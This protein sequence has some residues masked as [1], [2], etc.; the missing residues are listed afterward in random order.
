MSERN[1]DLEAT[2]AP[3][4]SEAYRL[5]AKIP[6]MDKYVEKMRELSEREGTEPLLIRAVK[7]TEKPR[8]QKDI[9]SG[10]IVEDLV[11][12]VAMGNGSIIVLLPVMLSEAGVPLDKI[13]E[14]YLQKI[15]NQDNKELVEAVRG[16][17]G[18]V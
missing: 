15:Q 1:K 2:S 5:I 4:R 10:N 8:K 16:M 9:P 3:E 18:I 17:M 12:E 6:E 14:N 11:S 7:T 13:D